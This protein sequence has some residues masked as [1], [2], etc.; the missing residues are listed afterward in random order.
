MTKMPITK[1]K[2]EFLKN[3]SKDG[4]KGGTEKPKPEMAKK[5]QIIK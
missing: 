1:L 3:H 2:M 4:K 5:K